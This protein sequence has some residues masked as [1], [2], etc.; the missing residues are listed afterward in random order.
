[1]YKLYET[2]IH[3]SFLGG[4]SRVTILH[5]SYAKTMV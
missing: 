1:M 5:Y 3:V 4:T 2:K